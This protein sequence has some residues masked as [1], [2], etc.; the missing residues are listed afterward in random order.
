MRFTS[1]VLRHHSFLLKMLEKFLCTVYKD[2]KKSLYETKKVCLV[3][4]KTVPYISAAL[5]KHW[6]EYMNTFTHHFYYSNFKFAPDFPSSK[7]LP[8]NPRIPRMCENRNFKSRYVIKS[9]FKCLFGRT[10]IS[11]GAIFPQQMLQIGQ[12]TA[13]FGRTVIFDHY[14]ILSCL[15]PLIC[16]STS[17]RNE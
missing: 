1:L 16:A 15:L 8:D 3:Q 11:Y 9:T 17:Y 12:R 5:K 4:K 7:N 14:S 6:P 13:F 2:S 10:R